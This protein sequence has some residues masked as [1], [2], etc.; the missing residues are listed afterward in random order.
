MPVCVS[1]CK[2]CQSCYTQF[3]PTVGSLGYQILRR[4]VVCQVLPKCGQLV[5][6]L[7]QVHVWGTSECPVFQHGRMLLAMTV[8]V[9]L[10]NAHVHCYPTIDNPWEYYGAF[11][12]KWPTPFLLLGSHWGIYDLWVWS[13][14]WVWI[15][16]IKSMKW[17]EVHYCVPL[18]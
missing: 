17:G 13:C 3:L 10:A 5:P 9:S 2:M 18:M 4:F 7:R 15:P 6:M 11:S 8:M 1:V 16:Q 14:M 12:R